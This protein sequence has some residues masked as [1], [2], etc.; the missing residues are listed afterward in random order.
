[1]S[2][3]CKHGIFKEESKITKENKKILQKERAR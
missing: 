3:T 2:Y 1:M